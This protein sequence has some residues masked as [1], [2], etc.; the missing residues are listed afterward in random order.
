MQTQGTIISL[1]KPTLINEEQNKDKI[2]KNSI[3]LPNKENQVS[4]TI[5]QIKENEIESSKTQLTV[6][7][8]SNNSCKDLLGKKTNVKELKIEMF[9]CKKR[10]H[11]F[12]TENN[13]KENKDKK[14]E[15]NNELGILRE[16]NSNI[17]KNNKGNII[18]FLDYKSN[19]VK[20]N[21]AMHFKMNKKNK[22]EFK[23]NNKKHKTKTIY[24]YYKSTSIKTN[25]IYN[26]EKLC[27][28]I[29]EQDELNEIKNK[30]ISMLKLTQRKNEELIASLREQQTIY[31]EEI[32][33]CRLDI[34]NMLKEISKLKRENKVRWFNEQEYNL[35]KLII[36]HKPEFN[37]SKNIEYWKEGKKI[38]DTKI[39]LKQNQCQMDLIQ[40]NDDNNSLSSFTLD[41]LLKEKEE[42][43]ETLKKLETDKYLYLYKQNLFNQEK[44]C[45]FSPLKKE[46][47][48][49]LNERYQILEL[50]GKGGYSEVYK[51]YDTY[52]HK[53][54]ACKLIQLNENWP[55]EIKQ[56]YI[57]HT[58]RENLILQNLNHKK[59]VK[60]Y[61][62]LEINDNS[63][64]NILEYCSGPDLSLYIRK[65][66][67]SISEQIAKIIITQ[68]LQALIYLN[69]LTKKIIH[70]DLKPENILFDS[71]MNIKITDFGLAKIIEP[72]TEFV[73]LTSQ[74]V[75]T[76]WYLPP[77]C[78]E[79]N[80]NIEIN[81]KVDIWS[82]GVILYEIIFN[83]KP[84][85]HGC[86]SQKKLVKDKIIQNA[87]SVEFPEN[88]EISEKC[89][90]FIQ[91]CLK[92][93][94]SERYDAFQAFNSEFIQ[95]NL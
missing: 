74:G 56:S 78:F 10:K 93:K 59:I 82:L 57:K 69:N 7:P 25:K 29:E 13:N 94:Q 8:P 72:N 54:I 65:N 83:K 15:E 21:I 36:I 67:G 41:C 35:G 18:T 17:E 62:T 5:N 4:S 43:C 16:K 95:D 52:D 47:L 42:L 85:G 3:N 1:L 31:D 89:K 37:K 24:D 92:Y 33:K 40:K 58:I 34:S 19:K 22:F 9:L 68:I 86:S 44:I 87:Y 23:N 60:L 81:S 11:S 49:F 28:K 80:K 53:F 48:P 66:G 46:G 32:N 2:S 51:A 71:D 30:E 73:Q 50:I 38:Y 26:K 61:D 84:F 91:N 27:K 14:S 75:G 77:E 20:K 70:Y 12:N 63:F 90:D 76:Y 6:L 64:C 39:K 79:E 55:Q 45:T 88:P